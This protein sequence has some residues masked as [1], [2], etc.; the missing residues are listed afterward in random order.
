MMQVDNQDRL[1]ATKAALETTMK[2]MGK[3]H[4][5]RDLLP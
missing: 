1:S 5:L 3:I 2:T 4:M